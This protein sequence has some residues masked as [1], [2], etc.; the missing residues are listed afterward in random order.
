[1]PM[2]SQPAPAPADP[3]LPSAGLLLRSRDRLRVA[4]A[5]VGAGGLLQKPSTE[6]VNAAPDRAADPNRRAGPSKG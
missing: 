2:M 1:M 5:S 3:L 6:L 4:Q